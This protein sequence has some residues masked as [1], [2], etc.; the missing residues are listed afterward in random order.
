MNKIVF[1]ILF[2]SLTLNAQVSKSLSV[3]GDIAKPLTIQANDLKK[4]KSY[5]VD[6]LRIL[7]H[8]MEYKSTLKNLK[9]VLLKD[10]LGKADFLVKSPKELSEFYIICM[11]DDDYKV[12]FSWNELFNSP[13]GDKTLIITD[14]DTENNERGKFK[15]IT[16]TDRATGRRYVKDFSK[17]IIKRVQ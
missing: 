7:N 13:A 8:K 3:S 4:Y 17:I 12:V 2:F 16:P 9:G 5:T 1:L 15:L 14:D 11:A 10:I 6:S